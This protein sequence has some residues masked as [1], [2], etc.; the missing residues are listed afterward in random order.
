MAAVVSPGG[1]IFCHSYCGTAPKQ[2]FEASENLSISTNLQ[3]SEMR[4]GVGRGSYNSNSK[5]R[6]LKLVWATTP[7]NIEG[8]WPL[9]EEVLTCIS[10]S[11]CLF[12]HSFI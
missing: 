7:G 5:R 4:P 2:N 12:I 6:V 1:W 3:V 8:T 9:K 10:G 11:N